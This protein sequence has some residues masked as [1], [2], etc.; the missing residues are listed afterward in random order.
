VA[1]PDPLGIGLAL[2]G[3]TF[4]PRRRPSRVVNLGVAALAFLTS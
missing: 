2:M 4:C 1:W 3:G